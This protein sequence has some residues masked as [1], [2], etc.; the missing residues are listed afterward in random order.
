M[1]GTA[2][3][4]P[5][6]PAERAET[7]SKRRALFS[8]LAIASIALLLIACPSDNDEEGRRPGGEPIRAGWHHRHINKHRSGADATSDEKVSQLENR[9]CG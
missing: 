5:P 9:Q 4:Y 6:S 8:R 1:R 3:V 7:I 2:G